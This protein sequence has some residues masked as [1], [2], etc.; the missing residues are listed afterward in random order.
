M[1]LQGESS[2]KYV[3]RTSSNYPVKKNVKWHMYHV[4]VP[5]FLITFR[6]FRHDIFT[7]GSR[8]LTNSVLGCPIN[9]IPIILPLN[10]ILYD[11]IH[12]NRIFVLI[13]AIQNLSQCQY[14]QSTRSVASHH[15]CF[16]R[17]SLLG[18]SRNLVTKS[19]GRGQRFTSTAVERGRVLARVARLEPGHF[20]S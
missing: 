1:H 18:T 15:H 3:D 17:V 16:K 11:R 4:S 19:C 20:E 12:I 13:L 9:L 14:M 7:Q 8:V 6:R 2:G 5:F 10:H